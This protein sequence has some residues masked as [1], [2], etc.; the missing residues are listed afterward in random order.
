M[1]TE[2][3][4]FRILLQLP[5][6]GDRAQVG[7]ADDVLAGVR[8]VVEAGDALR[9]P[10]PQGGVDG[11]AARL[12]V[13]GDVPHVPALGM[14]ADDGQ[15]PLR[16]IRDRA[17]GRVPPLAAG[18]E[19][20]ARQHALHGVRAGPAAEARVADGRQL[21]R[22][23]GRM[24]RLEVD[25]G[26]AQLGRERAPVFGRGGR[27]GVEQARHPPL[28]EAIGL[29][30]DR[31]LR[32]LRLPRALGRRAPEEHDGADQL[33]GQLL[34]PVREQAELLPVLRRLDPSALWWTHTP[35][36][37]IAALL[38]ISGGPLS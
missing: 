6:G 30:V 37:S 16:R 1:H 10:A 29:A 20:S 12:Q 15:A 24:L 22:A 31:P 27:R 5:H 11:L 25:D 23:E 13:G 33:V 36:A 2:L 4:Q 21:V 17:V 19:Q 28:V 32:L 14:Q 35:A 8:L 9:D 26:L 38:T 18:G 34:R 3:A 7:L